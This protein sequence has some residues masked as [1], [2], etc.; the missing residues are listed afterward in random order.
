MTDW[1]LTTFSTGMNMKE[2]EGASQQIARFLTNTSYVSNLG[3]ENIIDRSSQSSIS[4]MKAISDSIFVYPL[5]VNIAGVAC[6]GK[7][8]FVDMVHNFEVTTSP[9]A[10]DGVV[11]QPI[12]SHDSVVGVPKTIIQN[13]VNADRRMEQ[14]L[15]VGYV[16]SAFDELSKKSDRYRQFLHDIK[17]AWMKFNDG[18]V[19][20]TIGTIYRD[21]V[22]MMRF[23]V[24]NGII[25]IN[26]RDED[27]V[28]MVRTKCHQMGI[29]CINLMI[30]G[31]DTGKWEND[32][33]SNVNKSL[34]DVVIHN[35]GDLES[36]RGKAYAF[37][38]LARLAAREYGPNVPVEG[39]KDIFGDK[40]VESEE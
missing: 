24:S 11:F 9:N 26:N 25:F 10:H 14:W 35:D 12:M 33:D 40:D 13:I 19:W 30:D 7:D 4:L 1:A 28:S 2:T 39:L 16:D 3:G 34:A 17:D 15:P 18:P 32:C 5:V 23:N 31:R 22:G 6:T 8:S 38:K 29:C 36:L 21:I 27:S 37:S 20:H